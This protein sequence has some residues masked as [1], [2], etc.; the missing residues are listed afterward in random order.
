MY[1]LL[2]ISFHSEKCDDASEMSFN[3]QSNQM[4]RND[5]SSTM[6][7]DSDESSLELDV[8]K[9]T[10]KN[11]YTRSQLMELRHDDVLNEDM[12]EKV[13]N[14]QI[15]ERII[16][17]NAERKLAEAKTGG[18]GVPAKIGDGGPVKNGKKGMVHAMCGP[19]SKE[20]PK[21][22]NV[23]EFWSKATTAPRNR[24]A[25]ELAIDNFE[26]ANPWDKSGYDDPTDFGFRANNSNAKVGHWLKTAHDKTP[27][28][29][30]HCYDDFSMGSSPPN[31]MPFSNDRKRADT[32]SVVSDVSVKS[33]ARLQLLDKT[34]K[35]KQT[36]SKLK[37]QNPKN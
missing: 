5:A 7:G 21:E 8:H 22:P 28:Q 37:Q 1:C 18:G 4:N 30:S 31:P 17:K 2:F 15:A 29:F 13:K 27:T 33:A 20:E 11:E 24:N 36:L 14:M 32:S 34:A 26:L 12:S 10:P 3:L 6:S 25:P 35:L 9:Q 16:K 19:V 23:D